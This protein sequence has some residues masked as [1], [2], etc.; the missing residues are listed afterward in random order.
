[1][2]LLLTDVVMPETNG[3]DLAHRLTSLRPGMRVL[4]VSGYTG[5]AIASSIVE[6]GDALLHKPFTTDVLAGR[7]REILDQVPRRP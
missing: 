7:V 1:L 5:D 4:Y 6:T 3:R 2:H